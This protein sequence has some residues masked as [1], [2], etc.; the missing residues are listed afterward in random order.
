M[1]N[2]NHTKEGDNLG[3]TKV[4][5]IINKILDPKQILLFS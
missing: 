5:R 2:I 1:K 4:E 3:E